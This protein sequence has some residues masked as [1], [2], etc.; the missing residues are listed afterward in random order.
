MTLTL[1]SQCNHSFTGANIVCG[2]DGV[3]A[4]VFRYHANNVHSNITKVMNWSEPMA[5][6]YWSAIFKP[7]N[8][9]VGISKGF[10]FGL[11]VSILSLHQVVDI[12]W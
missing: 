9:K 6:S 7:L 1:A 11:K 10:N 5:N 12:S 2:S 8:M 4:C 3:V